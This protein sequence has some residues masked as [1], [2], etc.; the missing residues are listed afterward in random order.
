MSSWTSSEAA[1]LLDTNVFVHAYT[2]D[3]LSDECRGFLH[4]LER[5]AVQARL[6]AVILH[7]MSYVLPR[8]F[9]Q[10]TRQDLAAYLIMVLGWPGV[11]AEKA[12]LADTV[13]RWRDTPGLAFVDAYLAALAIRDG[14]PVFT[15]NVAE[16]SGQGIVIPQPLPGQDRAL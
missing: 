1:G 5:G 16:L 7:E 14:R 9:K 6:E 13:V 12:L 4:G 11:H 3:A 8:Y 10:M 15:K 2:H